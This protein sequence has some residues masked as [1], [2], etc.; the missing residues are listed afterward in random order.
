[1][2]VIRWLGDLIHALSCGYWIRSLHPSSM[3]KSLDGCRYLNEG[4]D[5][6]LN[7][8]DLPIAKDTGNAALAPVRVVVGSLSGVPIQT[9]TRCLS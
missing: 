4:S 3:R 5:G 6:G 8:S 2:I 1:V 7:P 9:N